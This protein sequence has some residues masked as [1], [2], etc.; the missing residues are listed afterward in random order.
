[1]AV[2]PSLGQ[3][4]STPDQDLGLTVAFKQDLAQQHTTAKSPEEYLAQFVVSKLEDLA[5]AHV[6]G[7]QFDLL[8]AGLKVA[9]AADDVATVNAVAAELHVNITIDPNKP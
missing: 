4:D 6:S 1:M 9:F 2:Y 7:A 5:V 8:V 3:I